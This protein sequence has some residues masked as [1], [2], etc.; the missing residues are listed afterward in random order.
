[1]VFGPNQEKPFAAARESLLTRF[2]GWLADQAGMAPEHAR[3][4]ACDAG[5]ALDWKW[6]Y[7]DG[8][9]GS[10]TIGD[11]GEFLL[12][13]CPRKLSVSRDDC[14]SIP[15]ALA[16]FTAFL[17]AEGLLTSGSSSVAALAAAASLATDE[18]VA[19][20]GDASN[21]GLAK[22]LFGAAA[23]DGVDLT[24]PD[25]L[26]DWIAEFNARPLDDRRQIIPDT[27]IASPRRPALPPVALPDDDAVAASKAE[28]PILAMFA[29]FAQFVGEGRKLTQT[30]NLTLADA[31]VLIG[32]LGTGD[33][34]DTRI[35]DRTFKT[36][37]A[38]ELPRL[39][40]MFAWA[41]K[42]GVVRVVHGRIVATKRGLAITRD[43]AAFYD[44]AV[45]ALLA[46]GPLASQRDP[47]W[48]LAWPEVNEFLD[49]S[50]VHLLSGPYVAQ[51]PVPIDDLAALAAEAVL[52]TFVF[53]P[54][55]DHDR[56][57]RHVAIDVVDLVDALELAGIL[58]RRD[59][60][61]PSDPDLTVGRRRHG[62]TV[63]LTPAGAATTR[64]LLVDAGYEAPIAGRFAAGTAV[65]LFLG[66]DGDD[67]AALW[68]E[69]QAWRRRRQPADA[70]RE[71]ADAVRTLQDP[72]LRNVALAV[73]SD[74]DTA[75]SGPEV[76]ELAAEPAC[77]GFALCWLVDH[78]LEGPQAL[79]DPDDVDW[80]VDVL[81]QRL[82]MAGPDGLC[83]TLALAGG[84]EAQIRA[85]G[86]LWR[87]PST[88]TDAVLAAI[89]E[90]HPA[91]IVA[92]AARKARFQRRSGVGA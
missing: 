5:L 79:F 30:G 28:S 7:A 49:R 66:T 73:M 6:S 3:E 25:R 54:L 57:E 39:R 67:I 26:Q 18:F 58:R 81:S 48:W 13:W 22:S 1:M 63:E 60:A 64:A 68:G 53:P 45:R 71:L 69:I 34:M 12:E 55:L 80:F 2:E 70:A 23:A 62:G 24:D 38:A 31:R 88:A 36:K 51:G 37:S 44:R 47:N 90:L 75:V 82:V 59:V 43:P 86:R 42:A 52:G 92:K 27:A 32:L 11:I 72:A 17:A 89:G 19:A 50:V 16:S 46:I 40:Q 91:K 76:R 61:G 21:F 78:G 84:H 9:L 41:K 4:A 10:W 14:R 15:G 74:I 85:I 20:M 65:D 8:D 87:S 83:D 35:G 77:R 29:G 56:V 33:E